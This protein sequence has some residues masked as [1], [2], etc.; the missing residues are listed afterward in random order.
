MSSGSKPIDPM[1]AF[2]KQ[3]KA[4]EKQ[5]RKKVKDKLKGVE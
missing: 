4:I 2:E 5:A 1:K 3:K